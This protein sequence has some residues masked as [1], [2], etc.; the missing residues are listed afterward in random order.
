MRYEWKKKTVVIGLLGTVLD[1]NLKAGRWEKWRPPSRSASTRTCWSIGWSCSTSSGPRRWPSWSPRT[2]RRLAR[3][4]G[5]P[6]D[7]GLRRPVGLRGGLRPALRLRPRVPVRPGERGVPGPHHHGHARGADLPVPADRVAALAGQAAPDRAAARTTAPASRA[8]YAIIDLDLSKYD[9]LASRF[10][11]T[12]S[13]T[14]CRS[15]SPA[16]RPATRRSTALIE[17]IERVAI[18]LALRRSC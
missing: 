13:A 1:S 14:T 7:D 18:A 2:S 11:R 17:Q 5:P 10:R 12:Q 4:R 15:S 9:R 8:R 6:H 16:S 3:D